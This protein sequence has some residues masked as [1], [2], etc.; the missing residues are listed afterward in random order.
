MTANFFCWLSFA[1]L[2]FWL[3]VYWQ[4]GTKILADIRSALVSKVS[5]LDAFLLVVLAVLGLGMT[6]T[7][8][9]VTLGWVAVPVPAW[10]AGIGCLLTL[11][12]IAGTFYC[13]SFL[14]KFW[15]AETALK[16]DH[17]VIEGGPYG[18][19]RHPIYSF[20]ILLYLGLG[21]VFPAWWNLPS[22]AG[23]ALGYTLKAWDEERFLESALNGYGEYKKRV[24]YRLVPGVW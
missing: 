22:A 24:R 19:V 20:A 2:L 16:G 5:R 10:L 3:L 14:G 13:R 17:A 1:G 11:A 23:I 12:G 7:A 15:T 8:A 4:G 6:V 9:L 18:V 21:L